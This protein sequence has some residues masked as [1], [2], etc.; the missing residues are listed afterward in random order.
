M[1]QTVLNVI[2][3]YHVFEV[4][5]LFFRSFS[6]FSFIRGVSRDILSNCIF[7]EGLCRMPQTL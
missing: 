7:V 2:I 1:A 3:I 5:L 4:A 6:S